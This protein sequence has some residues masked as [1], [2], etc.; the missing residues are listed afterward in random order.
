ML[1]GNKKRK[2]VWDRISN[3]Q[4]L[5]AFFVLIIL[6]IPV[7]FDQIRD[8][9][10]STIN[11][12]DFKEKKIEG[13]AAGTNFTYFTKQLG[14]PI[15]TRNIEIKGT[16]HKED[17]F[18][19]KLYYVQTITTKSGAVVYFSV[20]TRSP[21]FNPTFE[22]PDKSFKVTLGKTKISSLKLTDSFL[23]IPKK[24]Y[25]EVNKDGNFDYEMGLHDFNYF[26]RYYLA[27]PGN[28]QTVYVGINQSGYFNYNDTMVDKPSWELS[29]DDLIKIRKNNL[30]NTYA[31]TVPS[32]FNFEVDDQDPAFRRGLGVNY[33]DVRIFNF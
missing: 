16:E 12:I 3:L 28:Y 7:A 18:I 5:L 22:F 2:F 11:E 27:N 31:I 15:V 21:Q 17:Y 9:Y 32:Y 8:W 6:Q 23:T 33:N 29:S 30:I 14:D 13:L 19:D 24:F 4:L 1:G 26:E 20:T 25:A 10:N